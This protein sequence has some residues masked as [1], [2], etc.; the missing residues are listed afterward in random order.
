MCGPP[1][2]VT[3]FITTLVF[4]PGRHHVGDHGGT[5]AALSIRVEKLAQGM[6]MES[7]VDLSPR[8]LTQ[9]VPVLE[10]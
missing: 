8:H 9:T 5:P 6:E 3:A 4:S 10:G 7:T 1:K 2:A